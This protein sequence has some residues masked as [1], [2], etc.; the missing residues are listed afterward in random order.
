M[1]DH[2]SNIRNQSEK[3]T[4]IAQ[5]V[6]LIFIILEGFF[7]L[8]TLFRIPS[9]MENAVFLGF[10]KSRL[11]LMAI[12][13]AAL[14]ILIGLFISFFIPKMK[15]VRY[16]FNA[17]AQ[18]PYLSYSFFAIFW[19][20]FWIG[21]WLLVLRFSPANRYDST[22][23]SIVDRVWGPLVW[24][25]LSSLQMMILIYVKNQQVPRKISPLQ[26]AVLFT[27][28]LFS[29]YGFA[30]YYDQVDWSLRMNGLFLM[31]FIPSI[32]ALI[33]SVGYRFFNSLKCSAVFHRII[34]C[35]L[36]GSVVYLIYRSTGQWMGR[37]NTPSKAYWDLLAESFLNGRLNIQNP[38]TTHDLTFYN[39]KWYVPNPPLP[40]ILLMPFVRWFGIEGINMTVVSAFLGACN[41]VLVFLVLQRAAE[42]SMTHCSLS[43]NL[44]I[45]A[46]FAIGTNHYWLS[47]V[48]QM[49]FVSQLVT[50]LFLSL[51]CLSVI[52]GWSGWFNG[53]FLGL[54]I[55]SRPNI[56]PMAIFLAGIFL[57]RNTEFPKIPWK[58]FLLWGVSAG[59]PVI[60]SG[61]LLLFYNYLRF[62]DWTDFGYVTIHGADWILE[63]VQKYGMF[64][65][66]FF[67]SNLDVMIF[68]RP[69]LDF[70]GER[71]FFQPGISGYSIFIMTPPLIY[72]FR[73]FQKNWWMIGAWLS[74]L[75][76]VG[77]LLCYH[78]TG[79]EQIGFRY[80]MDA[81]LPILL[82]IGV[83]IGTKPSF[84]FKTLTIVGVLIN[85]LSIYWWYLGRA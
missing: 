31:V 1:N 39:G 25:M 9:E 40:A 65:F 59:I 68:R 79:A 24:G 62:D 29:Y 71:F 66:H 30:S 7:S 35:L 42:R 3:K 11:I 73:R 14:L 49:W 58:K 22:I 84:F 18:H 27:I 6:L 44:W 12:N 74:I 52:E 41:S 28:F 20:V 69:R 5:I 16:S 56:F 33:G 50:V 45:T 13:I 46:L 47:T 64:N 81:I 17:W 53:L 10:S 70:S 48:G 2:S 61:G 4:E 8:Y 77:L 38:P 15:K 72:L 57:W 75:L 19:V 85:F 83:G 80:L 55:L 21:L 76:T 63:A 54:A 32:I 36:I 78:N 67:K 37:W 60:I 43:A 34:I 82:I 23:G 51:A 26:T